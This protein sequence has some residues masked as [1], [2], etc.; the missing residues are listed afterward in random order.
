[1]VVAADADAPEVV[2]VVEVVVAAMVMVATSAVVMVVATV[3]VAVKKVVVAAVAVAVC[4]RVRQKTQQMRTTSLAGSRFTETT[5]RRRIAFGLLAPLPYVPLHHALRKHGRALTVDVYAVW[6]CV[7]VCGCVCACACVGGVKRVKPVD[8]VTL[9]TFV[10]C[11][12]SRP[13]RGA[14]E[15]ARPLTCVLTNALSLCTLV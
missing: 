3:R 9:V 8:I 10:A 11:A 5:T 1:M 12:R 2:E 7:D 14:R 4:Q 6:M 15:C 13:S